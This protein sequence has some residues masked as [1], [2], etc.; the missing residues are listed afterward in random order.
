MRTRRYV[1]GVA[2]GAAVSALTLVTSGAAWADSDEHSRTAG[3]EL[4][5]VDREISSVQAAVEK[6][7]GEQMTIEERLSNGELL[8]RSKDYRRAMN[9]FSEIIEK[10]E[11]ENQ[12]SLPSYADALWLRGETYYA[13][14]EYLSARSDY[15]AILDRGT[16]PP[17]QNY[18]GRALA[19]LVDVDLRVNDLKDL[20]KVFQK[21][22]Q[23]P[24]A[25]VDAGLNYAKGKAY[26]QKGEYSN[27]QQAFQAVSA[28][29]EYAHQARYFLGLIAIQLIHP[30]EHPPPEWANTRPNTPPPAK[31]GPAPNY[32]PAIDAFHQV[33]ELAPDTDDHRQV[34]DLAWM[35]IGRLFYEMEQYEQAR[36]AYSHVSRGSPEFDTMLYELAWVYVRIGD[37]QRAQRALEVLQVADPLSP[38]VGSGLLLRADLL[39]RAGAFRE[40]LQL[41]TGVKTNYLPMWEDVDRFLKAAPTDPGIYYEK[42]AQQQLDLLDEKEKLPSLAIRWARE[43]EDG[44]AAFAVIDDVNECNR[45]MKQS[46]DLAKRLT[47]LTQASNVV[48]A[49]PELKAGEER[50]IGLIDQIA[51]ARLDLAKGLDDDESSSVGGQLEQVRNERRSLMAAVADMPTTSGEFDARDAAAKRKWNEVS[52]TLTAQNLEIDRLQ[53]I[54]NGLLRMLKDDAQR[55]VARDPNTIARFQEEIAQDKSDLQLFRDQGEA[56]REQIEL[57]RAQIG[58]GDGS[59]QAD[60]DTR[61]RFTELLDTEVSL[62]VSGQAGT[63]AQSYGQRVQPLLMQARSEDDKLAAAFTALDDQVKRRAQDLQARIQKETALLTGYDGELKTAD[64]GKDGAHELVGDVAKQNFGI[65]LNKL[66]VI[67]LRAD[68]GITAQAWE[69]REEEMS[70]VANLQTEKA[71]EEQLLDEEQK[72][73]LD[74]ANNTDVAK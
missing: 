61:K 22:G 73:V 18:V 55:G 19:R 26:Y 44:P 8:Y 36:D 5:N 48:E 30:I 15:N 52:Q 54:V 31:V 60:R 13:A 11:M 43:A 20:D 51:R 62:V 2:A 37:N 50:A 39:L 1:R 10:L 47:I 74:D 40:A 67:V 64:T 7:K 71:R 53:A 68:V 46:Q 32:K 4:V 35:A 27:A 58:F 34:I 25:Q 24:P 12:T 69:V 6:A 49:F 56:I 9:V 66:G 70:R 14:H 42:L 28:G 3:A 16:V 45:L 41:Y 38:Y 33:T 57:A 65:V 63:K 29:T 72:E 23:V 21:L 17:F 59:Y